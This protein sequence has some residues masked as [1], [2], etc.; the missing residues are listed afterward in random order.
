LTYRRL[1]SFLFTAPGAFRGFAVAHLLP[2]ANVAMVVA[3]M[4]TLWPL[5]PG[6]EVLSHLLAVAGKVL[7]YVLFTL[8]TLVLFE[9]R[10]NLFAGHI[11]PLLARVTSR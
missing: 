5:A 2:V 3:A 4:A 8:P 10:T 11:R 1:W 7:L 9:R 6:G